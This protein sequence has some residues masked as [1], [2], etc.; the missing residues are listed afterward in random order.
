MEVRRQLELQR[1]F[2]ERAVDA[3]TAFA[4]SISFVYLHVLLFGGWL[5]LNSGLI[6]GIDPFDPFPFVMLAMWASVEAIFLSTFVLITQNRM[7]RVAER[8]AELDLQI[9]L[10][11][12]HEITRLLSMVEAIGSHLGVHLSDQGL[13]ELKKDVAPEEVLDKIDHADDLPP[14]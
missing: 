8:R 13:E 12:E 2:Q 4:G 1:S 3:I 5:V 14:Q 7:A 10:L 11:S 6:L 9:S